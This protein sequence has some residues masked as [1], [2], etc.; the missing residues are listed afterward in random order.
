[1]TTSKPIT[2]TGYYGEPWLEKL[3]PNNVGPSPV[4]FT[5]DTAELIRE[6]DNGRILV[7]VSSPDHTHRW[8]YHQDGS[9]C[10]SY[11]CN[12]GKIQVWWMVF[13]KTEKTGIVPAGK[14]KYGGKGNLPNRQSTRS[15][16]N[17]DFSV[18]AELPLDNGKHQ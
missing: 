7:K 17:D 9:R 14:W 18:K 15:F 5:F 10:N 13:H 12:H 6:L 8:A 2:V 3:Y 4:S 1:M 11:P 16:H